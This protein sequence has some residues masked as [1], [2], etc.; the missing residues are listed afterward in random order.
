MNINEILDLWEK[1]SIIDDTHLNR[2]SLNIPALHAKYLRLLL[3]AKKKVA[4]LNEKYN[5]LKQLKTKYYYGKLT[6]EELEELGWEPYQFIKPIKSEL[7][8]ILL[9]DVD[10]ANIYTKIELVKIDITTL[11]AILVQINQ[12]NFIIKNAI[13][14]IKFIAGN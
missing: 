6:R 3:D 1:D 7:D 2:E 10:L 11:E 14:Y 4:V 8:N 12:R 13:D 9:G 5:K